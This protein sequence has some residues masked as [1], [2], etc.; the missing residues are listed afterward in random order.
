M[1]PAEETERALLE[2]AAQW[3]V[4]GSWRGLTPQLL[5][6]V[7]AAE[8]N[9]FATA[10]VYDRLLRSPEH[11][12]FIRRIDSGRG[13]GLSLPAGATLAIVPG[14]CHVEYPHTGADGAR[15][16]AGAEVWGCPV[17]V[18][19]LP[20]LG[21]L[22]DNAAAIATWLDRQPAGPVLLVSLSK[23][24]ADVR[25]ALARPDLTRAFRNVRVW[26][27]LSGIVF[28]TPLVGWFLGCVHRRW[29]VRFLCW[30]HRY[31]FAAV[32]ELDR[33]ADGPLGGEFALPPNLPVIHLVGLPLASHLSSKL[34]RKT[35]ARLASWGPSDGGGT[36]LGDICRLPG[37]IYPVWGADHYMQPRSDVRPLIGQLLGYACQ[38]LQ[39][40][41]TAREEEVV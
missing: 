19:P 32:Q 10:L 36:L 5:R 24:G 33:H 7:A 4:P 16:R 40:T 1:M 21:R 2:R 37:M 29:F 14:A 22:A 27:N 6:Q 17:S 15:L 8:G 20:S 3:P 30:R 35:H 41:C 34:S 26:I 12:P 38:D 28:G 18:V 23:G 13:A 31:P 9:D 39:P 25:M 11:G